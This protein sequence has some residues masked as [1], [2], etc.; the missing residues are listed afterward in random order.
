VLQVILRKAEAIRKAT[1]IAVP[2][3][4]D[5]EGVTSA[6][7]QALML[8][9]GGHRE[10]LAFDFGLTSERLDSKWRDAEENA[11]AS[12]ARYAQGALKPEEVLPE[13]RQMRALNGG[14]TEV[15]RFT[16]RALKRVGAPLERAG[17]HQ[18]VHL[19]A[20]PDAIK[21]RLEARG[22]RGTRRVGFQDD[23]A[24]GVTHLGRVH[25]LVAGLAE[26]LA[27]GALDPDGAAFPPLGRCGAWRTRAVNQMTTLLLLR[28]RFKLITSGRTN[29]LLL[30]EEATALAFGGT[31]AEATL[32]GLSAL[33]LLEPEAAGNLDEQAIAR[34]LQRAHERLA[35]YEP[36]IAA[37]AAERG[38]VLSQ[39]H[40]RLTEAAR[41]GATVEVVPVLPADV[42]GLYV[43]LPED[44]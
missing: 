26:S 16:D 14:P 39:D 34:Q 31:A 40:L 8:R 10:Q 30:A 24:P 3:P 12:R 25:P 22:L 33:A 7:M 38:A 44:E 41:G 6:L 17:Q 2:M 13:W 1:G 4:E 20:M 37:F 11:K 9:A 36:A 18:L 19:D 28:L 35:T 21:E 27:E 5:S 15:A 23:P 43:L 29:R 42:I 32:T